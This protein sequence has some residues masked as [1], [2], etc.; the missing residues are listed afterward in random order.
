MEHL[1]KWAESSLYGIAGYAVEWTRNLNQTMERYTIQPLSKD[2]STIP[3]AQQI[4]LCSLEFIDPQK[5]K[6]VVAPEPLPFVL[7][8]EVEHIIY[9]TKGIITSITLGI[10]GCWGIHTTDSK[11]T[12]EGKHMV[13]YGLST[14]WKA[15]ANKKI[16]GIPVKKPTGGPRTVALRY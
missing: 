11:I 7:G 14:V 4:D 12:K 9:K 13:D 6:P 8:Q 1:G 3:D 5:R 10:N 16:I 15:T 2:G